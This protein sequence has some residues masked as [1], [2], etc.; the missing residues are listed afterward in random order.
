MFNQE[1]S[2]KTELEKAISELLSEMAG[3]QGDSPEYAAMVD[4]LVKLHAMKTE[5]RRPRISPD[6][7]ATIA[8]NLGGILIIVGHERAHIVTS[9]ALGFIKRLG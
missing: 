5:E 8:A 1:S 3:A 9:K 7:L 6:T 2:E 4:Q